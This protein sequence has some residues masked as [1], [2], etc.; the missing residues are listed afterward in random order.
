MTFMSY[1][2][3]IY[4]RYTIFMDENIQCLPQLI[5]T[6]NATCIATWRHNQLTGCFIGK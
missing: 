2:E 1:M 5:Y 3:N 6:V 4:N